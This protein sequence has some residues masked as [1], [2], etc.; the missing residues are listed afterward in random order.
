M[1]ED[2]LKIIHHKLEFDRLKSEIEELKKEMAEMAVSEACWTCG[3]KGLHSTYRDALGEY[4]L[5]CD[6]CH[7]DEYPEQYEDEDE[8]EDE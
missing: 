2:V 4:E 5:T 1:P 6:E 7:R 8:E 3:E